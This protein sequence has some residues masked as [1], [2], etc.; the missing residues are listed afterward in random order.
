MSIACFGVD[1][2]I[3]S[4]GTVS[5]GNHCNTTSSFTGLG[6]FEVID[7]YAVVGLGVYSYGNQVYNLGTGFRDSLYTC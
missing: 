7:A 1:N 4:D 3:Y 2:T 6:S 5:T